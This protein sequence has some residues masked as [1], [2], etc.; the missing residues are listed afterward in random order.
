MF[1]AAMPPEEIQQGRI[2]LIARQTRAVLTAIDNWRRS[3]QWLPLPVILPLYCCVS[4]KG[5]AVGNSFVEVGIV[6]SGSG[7]G[8]GGLSVGVGA[9]ISGVSGK[10]GAVGNSFVEVDIVVSGSGDGTGVG[11]GGLLVGVGAVICAVDGASGSRVAG[12]ALGVS[13]CWLHPHSD[14]PAS[15][16]AAV[17]WIFRKDF[18]F[19]MPFF[20]RR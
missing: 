18:I 20:S 3:D 13:L 8:A 12:G 5:G 4:G 17:I 14:K 2:F 16:L 7:D 15:A 1:L 11:A 10:G 6:V 9:V 19:V